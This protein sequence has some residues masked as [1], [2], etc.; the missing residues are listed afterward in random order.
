VTRRLL[1]GAAAVLALAAAAPKPAARWW[2]H[3]EFLAGERLQGRN[4]ASEGYRIAAG[5]VAAEFERA[6]LKPAGSRAYFQPVPLETRRIV[7]SRSSLAL[8]RNGKAEP[9]EL[10]EHA[11]FSLR[12]DPA[13]RVDAPL[14]F[15]GFGLTVPEADYDDLAGLDLR[16]AV[17]VQ[18]AGGPK[19]IT[20]PL[21]SHY[22]S[23]AR[24]RFLERAGAIGAITIPNP[25]TQEIPWARTA[26]A[27]LH[28]FM[29]LAD[30]ALDEARAM[31][32]AATWNPAHAGMLFSGTGHTLESL[33]AA[34]EAGQPLP[35][36]AL[37]ARVR[38]RV[39]VERG[40]AQCHNVVGVLPGTDPDLR[41]EY[42]VLSA[43]LDHL[44]ASH[45]GVYHGAMD[46]AAGV[47]SLIE[48]ARR[49]RESG[50]APRRSV[51]F[52]ALTAEEKG[53]LGSRWFAAHP[54]VPADGLVANL[55]VDMFLPLFPLRSVVAYGA[56]ESGLGREVERVAASMGIAL[57]DD[58]QPERNT[59][60]RS[61]QYS[62]VRGGVPALAFKLGYQKGSAQEALFREWLKTRYHATS[63]DLR[64]PVDLGAAE[65]FNEFLGQLAEAVANRP[66]RPQWNPDSF[67]RRFAR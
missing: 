44:G 65:R 38:A 25:Q 66:D 67:F 59:F 53:L 3:V 12:V 39:R 52:V 64:Q 8:V 16:G 36:F 51:L 1:L 49:M 19:G 9:L 31:R 33:L 14:V 37:P 46:N 60:A 41:R 26:S 15:A 57:D 42:V 23:A 6:G 30:R 40:K 5:Y 48:V 27:R 47:A 34:A 45:A 28:T 35:R 62:F 63:D 13:P 32:F 2:S 21:R 29:S 17:V 22:Q 18:L 61:D 24:Y 20:G 4:T 11:F 43:H 54:T 58:P 56:R 7:E 55:N 10:G 50:A